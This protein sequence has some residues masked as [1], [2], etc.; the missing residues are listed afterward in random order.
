MVIVATR[1]VEETR[2]L[3]ARYGPVKALDSLGYRQS[4]SVI[5]EEEDLPH[6]VAAAQQGHRNYAK[7]Q[8]TWFRRDDEM[9][10]LSGLG[11]EEEI[12]EQALGLVK[13]FLE[14]QRE[15]LLQ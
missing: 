9:H 15:G 14:Q 11:G 5:R 6:A 2:G 4:L 3:F 13:G 1:P 8:L 12:A 7:R 10:W